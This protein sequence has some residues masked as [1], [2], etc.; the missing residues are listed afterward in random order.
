MNH[1]NRFQVNQV[2]RALDKT[3]VYIFENLINHC[4]ARMIETATAVIESAESN[5]RNHLNCVL[6]Q[7]YS[8]CDSVESAELHV[9]DRMIPI[10]IQVK[11]YLKK[12]SRMTSF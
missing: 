8:R 3:F 12:S 1:K 11:R 2:N 10:L 5:L 9:K 6:I 7:L 4:K